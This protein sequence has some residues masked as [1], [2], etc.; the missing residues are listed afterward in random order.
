MNKEYKLNYAQRAQH[1]RDYEKNKQNGR[2]A[3]K[4]V[5]DTLISRDH[6]VVW[7][8]KDAENSKDYDIIV[9]NDVTVDV[10]YCSILKYNKIRI[11]ILDETHKN[12]GWA[13]NNADCIYFCFTDLHRA[14]FISKADIK[15]IYNELK[16]KVP[17][18]WEVRE[19]C[20]ICYDIDVD[21]IKESLGSAYQELEINHYEF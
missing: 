17:S 5:V 12:L 4:A 6:K 8:N 20:Q 9:G 14:I 19:N 7:V 3:E 1:Q 2:L 16:D 15:V 13:L 21:Y 11:Q 18:T 10:K